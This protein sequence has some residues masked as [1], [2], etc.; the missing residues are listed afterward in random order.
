MRE[1]RTSL[2]HLLLTSSWQNNR[3]FRA[4]APVNGYHHPKDAMAM[5]VTEMV[6]SVRRTG[7]GLIEWIQ[8][9]KANDKVLIDWDG[10]YTAWSAKD[11][12][13]NPSD[14]SCH[15][16]SRPDHGYYDAIGNPV[17]R[18]RQLDIFW[19]TGK[20]VLVENQFGKRKLRPNPTST[21]PLLGSASKG[22]EF[23]HFS[24]SR[25]THDSF[26]GCSI[27]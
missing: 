9:V 16:P 15:G 7:S 25:Q 23:W 21:W 4:S 22:G 3:T 26:T 17:A 18:F 2:P 12:H 14:Q 24:R 19:R 27:I 10:W 5:T 6:E 1:G 8:K 11:N 20:I 13:T